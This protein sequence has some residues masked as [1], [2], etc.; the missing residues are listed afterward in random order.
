MLPP[1]FIFAILVEISAIGPL[2]L[3]PAVRRHTDNPGATGLLVTLPAISLWA[4]ATGVTATAP[5]ALLWWGANNLV[6]LGAGVSAVGWFLMA[7][8][9]TNRL[10]PTRRTI[11]LLAL[12]PVS[13]Q[14]IVW[15]DPIHGSFY[16][17]IAPQTEGR[18]PLYWYQII[19]SYLLVA[20]GTA[21]LVTEVIRSTGIRRQQGLLLCATAAVISVTNI[22][23]VVSD[24]A[25]DPTPLS[26]MLAMAILYWALLEA[27]FLDLVPVG[28]SSAFESMADPVVTVDTDGRVVDSNPAARGLV[29]AGDNWQGT[30]VD[31]F[32]EPFSDRVQQVL[33]GQSVEREL[34]VTKDGTQRYFDLRIT[35]IEDTHGTLVVLR[36]VTELKEREE[37]LDLLRRVQSRVLRHNIRN[38]L[39]VIQGYSQMYA[40]EADERQREIAQKVVAKTDDLVETSDKARAIEQLVDQDQTPTKLDLGR[41]LRNYVATYQRE[42]QAVSFDLDAPQETIVETIPAIELAV[43]NLVQNAAEHNDADEPQVTASLS[44]TPSETRITIVDNGPGIPAQEVAVLER[45]KETALEHGTG[46]G[47][48]IV[49]WVDRNSAAS[50]EFETTDPG[51]RVTVRIPTR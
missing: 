49:G 12:F 38:D 50:I 43:D 36:E 41:T 9:Y 7:T 40:D 4:L 13:V 10:T 2:L 15:T 51:T 18:N 14:L 26:F 6:Y 46:V 27:D 8:E 25:I 1:L 34:S 19:G 29:E 42:F 11:A 23:F 16:S 39:T 32:F 24:L 47:M 30:S 22:G 44:R 17:S 3:I 37:E 33:A 31:D 28:R 5:T 21:L 35:P 20:A 45:G 48:W